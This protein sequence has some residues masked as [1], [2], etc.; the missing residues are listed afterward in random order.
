[1]ELFLHTEGGEDPEI[2][3]VEA[4]AKIRTLLT[5]TDPDG[6]VWIEEIDEE[7]DLDL[8]FEGADIHHR[9][10]VH[11]GRCH[12][13]DV[14]VQ[15]NA[16]DFKHEY[17]PATTIKTVKHWATGD[18][19]A[20]LSPEQRAKHVLAIPGADHYLADG[21]HVGS[22]LTKGGPCE[23]VLDLLPEDAFAG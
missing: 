15:F 19:A 16:K 17:G 7:I 11:R 8:T 10:H 20:D 21:V 3:E 6:R 14:V 2:V 23:V 4:T 22:L 13:I 5:E 9:H 12:R 18:K 1:M